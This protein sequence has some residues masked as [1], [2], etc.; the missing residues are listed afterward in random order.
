MRRIQ[1]KPESKTVSMYEREL[2]YI[3]KLA[4]LKTKNDADLKRFEFVFDCMKKQGVP[5][6]ANI[7]ARVFE[8]AVLNSSMD[9]A[10][11]MLKTLG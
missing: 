9:L 7:R 5:M 4:S 11:S 1:F 10:N 3:S 6:N 2:L 8:Y